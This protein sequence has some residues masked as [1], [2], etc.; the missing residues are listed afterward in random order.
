MIKRFEDII[1][2]L[3]LLIFLCPLFGI[4]GL[5]IKT[6]SKG[7]VF[8]KQLRIGYNG[9][10][11]TLLKFRTMVENAEDL[12]RDLVTF[13]EM[14]GPVFKLS[15]DP[16]IT[17]IGRVL[18]RSSID[19][20]PQIINVLKGDMSLVGPRPSLPDEVSHYNLEDRRRLSM[21]PGITCLWQVS[22]RNGLSFQEWME[23][24][25]YYVDRWS[26]WLDFKILLRTIP[27]V[28]KGTGA[29]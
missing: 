15:G 11:F 9:R 6:T 24:D 21:K 5:L 22:G 18:R 4:V 26:L 2:S 1:I 8:F 28:F 13:N 27:A 23:L 17:K 3:V 16:R 14:D 10:L 25:R 20:L 7:P 29:V 12:R 19:E